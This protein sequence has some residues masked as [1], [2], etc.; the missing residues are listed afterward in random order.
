MRTQDARHTKLI[1]ILKQLEREGYC[2]RESQALYLGGSVTARRLEA[3]L[4][5]ADVPALFASR[6]EH[7]MFKPKGWMSQPLGADVTEPEE[8]MS[9]ERS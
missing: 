7:V 9:S 2:S 3:M 6:I 5:G 4:A 8:S 1:E